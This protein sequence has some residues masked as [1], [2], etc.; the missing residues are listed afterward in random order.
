M[1]SMRSLF[2][3]ALALVFILMIFGGRVSA[4]EQRVSNLTANDLAEALG[5]HWWIVKLPDGIGPK[6]VVGV[7]AV[8]ADGKV[9]QGGGGF[10]GP[11]SA[12]GREIR[13]YCYEDKAAKVTYVQIKTKGGGAGIPFDDYFKDA[14]VGGAANGSVL[15]VGD[16][17]IKFDNTKNVSFTGGNEL[18][19]GQVG[20]KVVI[21]HRS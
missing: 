19:P 10:S 9:L 8:S 18:L 1:A 12:L 5:V 20:L 7:E 15:N 13:I 4:Q 14:G 17:L 16:I 11:G 21:T 6:D 3:S 2:S